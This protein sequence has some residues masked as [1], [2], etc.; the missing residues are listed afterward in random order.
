[1]A[2]LLRRKLWT[3]HLYLHR[4]LYVVISYGLKEVKGVKRLSGTGLETADVPGVLQ[5]GGMWPR[6]YNDTQPTA[7]H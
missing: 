7:V 4:Y 6:R 2:D 5:G 1:M 3:W